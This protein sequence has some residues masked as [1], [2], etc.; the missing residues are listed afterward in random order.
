MRLGFLS[1]L[2]CPLHFTA[3]VEIFTGRQPHKPLQRAQ[4]IGLGIHD[5]LLK[6]PNLRSGAF[7]NQAR[8]GS[9]L[10][11]NVLCQEHHLLENLALKTELWQQLRQIRLIFRTARPNPVARRP[12]LGLLPPLEFLIRR[13]VQFPRA[14]DQAPQL[15]EMCLPILHRL[16]HHHAVKAF[17]WGDG[18]ELL[19]QGDVF[20][21]GEPESVQDLLGSFLGRLDFFADADFVI[22]IQQ[23]HFAHLPEVDAYRVFEAVH[24]GGF[25]F[26][27]FFA[28]VGAFDLGSVD[29]L[30]VQV[31]QLGEHLVQLR[32]VGASGWQDLRKV[33]VGEVALLARQTH[34]L[35]YLGLGGQGGEIRNGRW[36]LMLHGLGVAGGAITLRRCAAGAF[37]RSVWSARPFVPV[38]LV[39]RTHASSLSCR[40]PTARGF[41]A[42]Q[43]CSDLVCPSILTTPQKQ[44]S[45]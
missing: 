13:S 36:I 30:D 28:V 38:L 3:P 44:A 27:V 7:G 4:S 17:L 37:Q 34:Q 18:E 15:P 26:R 32:G 45:K 11:S 20:L 9:N 19:R 2:H 29:D 16:I 12:V 21:P 23:G 35:F 25:F 14:L 41:H 24:A 43:R 40:T 31:P 5:S 6:R 8:V 42:R 22:A 10:L 1:L 39:P 33:V